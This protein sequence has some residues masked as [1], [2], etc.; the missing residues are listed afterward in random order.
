MNSITTNQG[1]FLIVLLIFIFGI[2]FWN[3]YKDPPREKWEYKIEAIQDETFDGD[4]N[5]LGNQGWELV[6]ARRASNGNKSGR[7]FSYEI[8]F[9]KKIISKN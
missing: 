4:I 9:K 5:T 1:N 3:G 8:I 7:D 6:F 2:I